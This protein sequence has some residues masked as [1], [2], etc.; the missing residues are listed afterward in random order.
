MG[1]AKPIDQGNKNDVIEVKDKE[2]EVQLA[3]PKLSELAGKLSSETAEAM[4]EYVARSRKGW[5]GRLNS[6]QK[7]HSIY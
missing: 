5:E 1:D 4:L 2:T 6:L 7:I 3:K